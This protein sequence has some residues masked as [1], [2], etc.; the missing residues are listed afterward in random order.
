MGSCSASGKNNIITQKNIYINK[1]EPKVNYNENNNSK[2]LSQKPSNEK[3]I[4]VIK[5]Q[6]QTQNKEK[7]KNLE[8][9]RKENHRKTL[10]VGDN[11]LFHVKD[12]L[13]NTNISD[14]PNNNLNKENEFKRRNNRSISLIDK[15]K[16]RF[17]NF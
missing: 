3:V 10:S 13:S 2:I 5:F 12:K 7:K 1:P 6:D 11:T 15:K 16:I 4:N 14:I 8:L 9:N 17:S